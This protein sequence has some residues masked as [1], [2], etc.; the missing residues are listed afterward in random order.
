MSVTRCALPPMAVCNAFRKPIP[1][2]SYSS[3]EL[4]V[5]NVARQLL[6]TTFSPAAI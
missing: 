2:S 3:S 5:I 1:M 4:R 6:S